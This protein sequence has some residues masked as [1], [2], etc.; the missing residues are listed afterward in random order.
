MASAMCQVQERESRAARCRRGQ[1][2]MPN[3]YAG[4]TLSFMV[5]VH[6]QGQRASA[7]CD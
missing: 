5:E 7:R 4:V 1:G 2:W 6:I 3:Y